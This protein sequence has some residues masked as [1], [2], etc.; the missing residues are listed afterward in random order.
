VPGKR[1]K[2]LEVL[3]H[4]QEALKK[5]MSHAMAC[6]LVGIAENTFYEWQQIGEG[7]HPK[8]EQTDEHTKFTDGIK[9]AEAQGVGELLDIIKAAAPKNW[10]AAAWL[11]ERRFHSVYAKR[12]YKPEDET[13][14]EGITVTFNRPAID[15]NIQ[16]DELVSF[17]DPEDAKEK[18][19]GNGDKGGNGG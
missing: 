15:V 1:P 16:S 2:P 14:K 11:L 3:P 12:T 13:K 6:Q 18:G 7:R 10:T 4:L 8:R 17:T 9:E 19:S 5:G